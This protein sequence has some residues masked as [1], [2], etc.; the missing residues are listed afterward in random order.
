MQSDRVIFMAWLWQGLVVALL[1]GTLMAMGRLML[2][3]LINKKSKWGT[4]LTYVLPAL[5]YGVATTTLVTLLVLSFH[6]E[7]KLELQEKTVTTTENIQEKIRGWLEN[8]HYNMQN[9]PVEGNLYFKYLITMENGNK[10]NIL[11][12]KD[13]DHYITITARLLPTQEVKS[14]FDKLTKKQGKDLWTQVRIEASRRNNATLINNADNST[15]LQRNLP[16][17]GLTENTFSEAIDYMDGTM[18]ILQET[19]SMILR[20]DNLL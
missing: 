9:E 16:V 15:Y 12:L 3:Y 11:R 7:Q 1:A 5:M 8:L 14:L 20:H 17:G 13:K 2:T 6:I 18:V 19:I 10:I 4:Y